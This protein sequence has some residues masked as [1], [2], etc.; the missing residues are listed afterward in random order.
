MCGFHAAGRPTSTSA[1]SVAARGRRRLRLSATTAT[2][3]AAAA[4]TYAASPAHPR[5]LRQGPHHRLR[6][7]TR[8]RGDLP[9]RLGCAVGKDVGKQRFYRGLEADVI[10]RPK[11]KTES[12]T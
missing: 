2:T 1:V 11:N 4:A 8:S 6:C 5:R 12:P 3:A 9:G 7:V 10:F